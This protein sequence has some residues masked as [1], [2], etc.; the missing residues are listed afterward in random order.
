M[1]QAL[2]LTISLILTTFLTGCVAKIDDVP[3]EERE[4]WFWSVHCEV[5]ERRRFTHAAYD[6]RKENDRANLARDIR[7]NKTLAEH[8]E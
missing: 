8:C 3:A 7:T 6:W 1:T 2:T 5:E 4:A